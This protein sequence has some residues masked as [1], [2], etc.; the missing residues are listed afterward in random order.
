MSMENSKFPMIVLDTPNILFYKCH[1]G[2][3]QT[4]KNFVA[5]LDLLL[6]P[7]RVILIITP[8]L[9]KKFQR[10]L[11]HL[12]RSVEQKQGSFIYSERSDPDKIVLETAI[13][14][15]APVVSNDKFRELQY[16]V[17]STMK[18]EII[19][20]DIKDTTL[21]PRSKR[22]RNLLEGDGKNV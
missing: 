6:K 11:I 5:I 22:W 3:R 1:E 20:F 13:K 12:R 18:P 9:L 8:K 21:V 19:Q 2:D 16:I 10:E 17:H 4:S 15:R 14:K 7:V